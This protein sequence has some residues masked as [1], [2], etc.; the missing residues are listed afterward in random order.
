MLEESWMASRWRPVMALNYAFIVFFDFVIAP[1]LWG[2][3]IY[4]LD[5][6]IL[7]WKPLTLEYGGIFHVAMGA[8]LGI[9][10]WT[11]GQEKIAVI[12]VDGERHK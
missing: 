5:G 11:R 2:L 6:E 7:Q 12:E 10:A 4:L 8:V 9:S 3:L 1:I